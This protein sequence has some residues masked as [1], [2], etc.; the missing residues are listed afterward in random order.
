MNN[1]PT[2]YV[3]ENVLQCKMRGKVAYQSH[4]PATIALDITFVKPYDDP[5]GKGYQRPVD[6]KRCHDFAVYLSKGE[7][8]LFTP[9][10][11]NACGNWEFS[12][13]DKI[14]PNY[15]RLICKGKASLMDGQ[16]RLGGIKKYVQETNSDITI[17]FLAF[18]ALDDDEEIK[19]FDTINT[20][21]KGIGPSLSK[22]LRRDTDDLSWVATELLMRKESPFLLIG[23]IIGKR[24]KGRHITLQNLYRTLHLL[25]KE[26]QLAALSKEEK[27]TIALIYFTAIKE[28]L[29]SEWLDYS[30][31]R[32]THIVCMDALSIAAGN[33]LCKQINNNKKIV[34]Y[35]ALIK[36]VKKLK[37]IDWSINGPLRFIKGLTGSRALSH[38]I[39]ELMIS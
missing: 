37:H 19:L 20:K 3:I 2:N 12:Y 36:A 22:Y 29:S 39:T 33:V 24:V 21:A 27:L 23:S 26:N 30:G 18:H 5:A 13:Y 16:H 6:P 32:L 9:V 31:H 35:S 28:T 34:D 15:G 17:P 25:F 38:E 11:L 14:R 8:A 4:L 10:L 1:L 7:D